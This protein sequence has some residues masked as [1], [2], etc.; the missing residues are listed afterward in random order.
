MSLGKAQA[1]VH[2]LHD[3]PGKMLYL[4][5]TVF[6][7]PR[8]FG[9]SPSLHLT[10]CTEQTTERWFAGLQ[11]ASDICKAQTQCA[12]DPLCARHWCEVPQPPPATLTPAQIV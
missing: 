8:G 3:I 12:A 9:D 5:G 11:D 4:S 6:H 10:G 1:P 7:L 2:L